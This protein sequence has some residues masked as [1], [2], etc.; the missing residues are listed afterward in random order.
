MSNLVYEDRWKL[1]SHMQKAVRRGLAD[2]AEWA[3]RTLWPID[4]AYVRTRLAVIAVEDVAGAE[5]E[6]VATLFEPG[7][8]KKHFEARGGVDAI[9]AAARTLALCEKDRTACDM[10]SCRHWFVEFEGTHGRWDQMTPMEAVDLA[11]S[12]AEPWWV[13]ALAAWRAVGTRAYSDR[14]E[15][16]PTVP[17]DVPLWLESAQDHGLTATDQ[18]VLLTAGKAQHEPHPVFLPLAWSLRRAE[19]APGAIAPTLPLL[20][21]GK[22][23]PWL[24]AALDGHTAEGRRAQR[25]LMQGNR[26]GTEFLNRHGREGDD[27]MV[28]LTKLWFWMEG[29]QCDRI[30]TYPSAQAISQDIRRRF[31]RFPVPMD[32]QAFFQ[33]FGHKPGLWQVARL[34][35]LGYRLPASAALRSRGPSA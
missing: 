21:L 12:P 25:R 7:W 18:A 2:E 35:A 22:V 26:A 5:S 8:H 32:G 33:H 20:E 3:A 19:L 6:T 23:G 10:W 4:H 17:G 15:I 1:A 28:A 16:L 27:A 14:G 13:R 29:G 9:G 30:Q 31:L 34:E 11:W 24:S